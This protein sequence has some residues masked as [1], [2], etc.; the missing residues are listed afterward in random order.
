MPLTTTATELQRNYR[1]VI[2]MVKKAKEPVTVLSNNK[3][4]VVIMDHRSFANLSKDLPKRNMR[5]RKSLDELFGS[6]SKEEGD[7]FNRVI[8]AMFERVDPESWK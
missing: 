5:H 1:K 6:W 3:P 2:R 4:E 7:K 8:E